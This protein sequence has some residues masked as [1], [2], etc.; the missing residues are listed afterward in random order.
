MHLVYP[1][2]IDDLRELI[3]HTSISKYCV[4]SMYRKCLSFVNGS[5]PIRIQN[6]H[7]DILI[8]RHLRGARAIVKYLHVGES[9]MFE[10]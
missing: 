10:L 3:L 9:F 5:L 7:T 6:Q 2:L 4:L 8:F 1:K